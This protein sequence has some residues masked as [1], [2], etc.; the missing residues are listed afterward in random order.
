MTA[1]RNRNKDLKDKPIVFVD[2]QGEVHDDINSVNEAKKAGFLPT[3]KEDETPPSAKA[4]VPVITPDGRIEYTI[5]LPP[6]AL[7]Y[8]NVAKAAGFIKDPE[9]DFDQWVFDCIQSKFACE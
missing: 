7:A 2:D 1:S 4:G 8:F 9:A 5:C 3:S 6:L